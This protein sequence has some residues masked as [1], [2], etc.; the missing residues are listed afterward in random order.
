VVARLR[1]QHRSI[2]SILSADLDGG[3]GTHP[4]AA[5]CV[6]RVHRVSVC[7]NLYLWFSVVCDKKSLPMFC[8][9]AVM[10]GMPALPLHPCIAVIRQLVMIMCR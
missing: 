5:D 7:S 2:S 3:A 1:M 4:C 10:C 8:A 6:E 9:R